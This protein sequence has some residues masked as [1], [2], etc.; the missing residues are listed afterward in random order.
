MTAPADL[1]TALV[2]R[3]A[4]DR[5][6]GHGGL[7]RPGYDVS[8]NGRFIVIRNAAQSA[9]VLVAVNWWAKARAQLER[10]MLASV[11]GNVVKLW[12]FR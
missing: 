12:T 7:G 1:N 10:L 6:I 5:H 11:E 4:I 2:T 8:R 3:Y 9:E